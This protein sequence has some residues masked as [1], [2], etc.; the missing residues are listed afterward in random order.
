MIS[1][2]FTTRDLSTAKSTHSVWL[3]MECNGRVSRAPH[4][5]AWFCFEVTNN[6]SRGFIPR[7]SWLQAQHSATELFC[8]PL[9]GLMKDMDEAVFWTAVEVDRLIEAWSIRADEVASMRNES[10]MVE[11]AEHIGTGKTAKQVRAKVKHGH[12][13]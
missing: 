9:T 6:R 12:F 5:D 13:L 11:I 2:E 10:A 3:S 7:F 1:Y 4:N 8:F